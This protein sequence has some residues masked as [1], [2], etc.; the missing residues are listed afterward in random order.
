VAVGKSVRN[1]DYLGLHDE[2]FE[3]LAFLVAQREEPDLIKPANPDLGLDG[4]V[5][6][7]QG[8]QAPRGLQA[9]AATE[10]SS[11]RRGASAGH[12]GVRSGRS[13]SAVERG[14]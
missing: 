9:K 1:F 7:E 5:L 2:K 4:V 13:W 14:R 11:Q 6:G 3:E 10:P 12:G 8:A